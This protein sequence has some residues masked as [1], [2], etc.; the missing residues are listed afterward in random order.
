MPL[1]RIT[2][3]HDHS[4]LRALGD[5]VHEALVS[6]VGIPPDDRFQILDGLAPEAIVADRS[7]LGVARERAVFVEVTLRGGR[8]R[9]VKRAFYERVA[10]GASE[11]AGIRREDVMIVLHENATIDWSFGNGV[12]QYDPA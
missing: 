11:R 5:V 6:A 10:D 9:E 2:G 3:S 12:A 7:F 4:T 8:T 1:V